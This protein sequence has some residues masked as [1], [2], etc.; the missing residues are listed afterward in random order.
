MEVN[1]ERLGEKAFA[2]IG[3]DGATNFGIVRGADGSALLIDA[4]IRRIDEIEAALKRAECRGVKYLFITHENFDHASANDYFEKKG[5]VVIASQGCFD[6]LVDDGDAKFAEMAGRSPELF[7]RYPGLKMRFPQ[8]VFATELT[9]RLPGAAVHLRHYNQSHSRGDATAYFVEEEIFFAGDLLYTDYHPV[10][11]YG[12]I[13]SWVATLGAL[14]DVRY[15]K[16]MPG[17]GPCGHDLD[18]GRRQ[19]A[20]FERYLEEFYRRLGEAKTGRKSAQQ[21]VDETYE[22]YPSFGKRW[23]VKRNVEFFLRQEG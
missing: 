5:A 13:E 2:V 11:I 7:E 4:D 10:T 8:V 16:I 12:R 17:H 21:I 3:A 19:V 6:A 22:A 9:L 20:N 23:M 1:L 18:T 15:S 14:K